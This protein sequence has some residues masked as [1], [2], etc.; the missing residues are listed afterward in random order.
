MWGGGIA[1]SKKI[2]GKQSQWSL[3]AALSSLEPTSASGTW[4]GG[5]QKPALSWMFH[6]LVTGRVSHTRPAFPPPVLQLVFEVQTYLADS[7]LPAGVW[8]VGPYVYFPA[9]LLNTAAHVNRAAFAWKGWGLLLA[10]TP[11]FSLSHS[12][13]GAYANERLCFLPCWSFHL[14]IVRGVR[15]MDTPVQVWARSL[16]MSLPFNQCACDLVPTSDRVQF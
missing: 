5:Q 4:V 10:D 1:K 8:L 14:L 6:L 16:E 3:F 12:C 9:W 11:R 13:S 2:L 15:R 7:R